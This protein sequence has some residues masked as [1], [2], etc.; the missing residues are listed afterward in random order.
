MLV[1]EGRQELLQPFHDD[2]VV[3]VLLQA[4]DDD[5]ADDALDAADPHGHGAAVDGVLA[6]RL[7]EHVLF[8][9]RL[10]VAVHLVVH[11]PR[12]H[13]PPLHRLP[14][15]RDPEVVV[16]LDARPRDGVEQEVVAARERDVDHGREVRQRAQ[17]VADRQPDLQRVVGREVRQDQP[18]F[19]FGDFRELHSRE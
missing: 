4:A 11:E 14:L 19:L 3:L 16:R 17:P 18:L 9:E 5:D 12:T 2:L 13:P 1:A 15:A 7:A 6:G 8:L 10:L